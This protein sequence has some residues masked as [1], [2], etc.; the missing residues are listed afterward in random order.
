VIAAGLVV[1]LGLAYGLG[2]IFLADDLAKVPYFDKEITNA[3]EVLEAAEAELEQ[4]AELAGADT[5]SSRC[6]VTLTVDLA[7]DPVRTIAPQVLCGPVLFRPGADPWV[8]GSIL[9]DDPATGTARFGGFTSLISLPIRGL[10]YLGGSEPDRTVIANPPTPPDTLLIINE[11]SPAIKG[12]PE[13]LEAAERDFR[14]S[15]TTTTQRY[16][17]QQDASCW[18]AP[19]ASVGVVCGPVLFANSPDEQAAFVSYQ[20]ER[21]TEDFWSVT[22]A[23]AAN[24]RS[25]TTMRLPEQ[26][27]RHDAVRPPTIQIGYPDPD[28]IE[29]GTV[30][31]ID[32]D[33][34]VIDEPDGFNLVRLPFSDRT[35]RVSGFATTDRVGTGQS[36]II[37]AP[38]Q[39][40]AVVRFDTSADNDVLRNLKVILIL[41]DIRTA[42]SIDI[43]RGGTYAISIPA[44]TSIKALLEFSD[45]VPFAQSIDLRTG[46]RSNAG[47]PSLYRATRS[48]DIGRNVTQELEPSDRNRRGTLRFSGSVERAFV[49]A[50]TL[51]GAPEVH[52]DGRSRLT[53]EVAYRTSKSNLSFITFRWTASPTSM[54]AVIDGDTKITATSTTARGDRLFFHFDVPADMRTAQL[55]FRLSADY[56][57]GSTIGK[58]V[59]ASPEQEI[60]LV[61]FGDPEPR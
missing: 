10:K 42:Q 26:V 22:L 48:V 31:R 28:P 13:V 1:V 32:A 8:S 40:L 29:P 27:L 2:S 49:R 51:P 61:D 14:A 53:V 58:V 24:S 38:G 17:L 25:T 11:T 45:E 18:L 34:L 47:S 60:F 39:T 20:V 21:A 46:Q 41:R 52:P 5:S 36:A 3:K 35:V 33:A 56:T 15:L 44:D 23:L 9:L 57:L 43:V 19:R 6:W 37:A 4:Q 55:F 54:R 30:V 7:G 59:T 16:S 12:M 50:T